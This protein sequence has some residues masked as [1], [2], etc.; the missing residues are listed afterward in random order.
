MRCLCGDLE[1]AHLP[2]LSLF[3][4][5]TTLQHPHTT[6]RAVPTAAPARRQADL[7]SSSASPQ[8]SMSWFVFDDCPFELPPLQ[9]TRPIV[10]LYSSC[11]PTN[12]CRVRFPIP[13]P[14]S[15]FPILPSTSIADPSSTLEQCSPADYRCKNCHT[16]AQLRNEARSTGCVLFLLPSFPFKHAPNIEPTFLLRARLSCRCRSDASMF[17]CSDRCS[18]TRE[19]TVAVLSF[20]SLTSN[21][22]S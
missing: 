6:A 1:K 13:L 9:L 18:Y 11:S 14:I 10:A 7:T 4:L 22:A 5:A 12:T 15:P 16:S 20:A 8:T 3:F 2:R 21:D 17:I 19:S